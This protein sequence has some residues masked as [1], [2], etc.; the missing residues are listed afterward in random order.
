MAI[1]PF[2]AARIPEDLHSKLEEHSAFT[3]EGKT[4]A[5]INALAKYLN[6]TPESKNQ[7]SAGDRLSVLER[8]VAE[9]E[10]FLKEPKQIS[11]ALDVQ[12]TIAKETTSSKIT[13]D[14][15]EIDAT[16]IGV[17]ITDNDVDN[18]ALAEISQEDPLAKAR[19]DRGEYI[20][21]MRTQDIPKL[22]GLEG[23]DPKRIKTR[24]NNTKNTKRQ[25]T[26][27]RHYLIELVKPD[28][29]AIDKPK[30]QKA[31]WDVYEIQNTQET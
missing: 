25:S 27:I 1:K 8:K 31:L 2:I 21:R 19:Q 3:G 26:K 16:A 13:T 5:L 28:E 12:P 6:F 23:E 7:E 24:L 29:V 22:A 30:Y 15:E 9:L 11:M 4:Q 18:V 20:G 10:S 14:N 17:I